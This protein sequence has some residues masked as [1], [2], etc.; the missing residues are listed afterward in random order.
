MSNVESIIKSHNARIL[1]QLNMTTNNTK[2]CN[3]RNKGECPLEGNCLAEGVIYKATLSTSKGEM[4]Y[5]G[6]TG[7]TFKKR[8]SGH[9]YTITHQ[10]Q[11]NNTELS[12]YFWKQ[13]DKGEEPKIKWRILH[14]IRMP[15]KQQ[16]I[17]ALCN[18]E[19]IEIASAKRNRTLNKRKELTG[20]CVHFRKFY[21]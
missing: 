13:K 2:T 14:K 5:I 16:K 18:L 9:K 21:F 10:N 15:D 7:C 19:R 8:F 6:S 12:K 4:D 11:Q 20:S 1:R 17:C 3:C